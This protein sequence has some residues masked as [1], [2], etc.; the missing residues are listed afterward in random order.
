LKIAGPVNQEGTLGSSWTLYVTGVPSGARLWETRVLVRPTPGS[1]GNRA[2]TERHHPERG[3]TPLLPHSEK[4]GTHLA[5][6]AAIA[7]GGNASGQPADLRT[8]NSAFCLITHAGTH[9]LNFLF[10]KPH[11]LALCSIFSPLQGPWRI[12]WQASDS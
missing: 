2:S 10:V 9:L 5:F 11:F 3:D 8:K 6:S 4:A 7:I 12:R 1:L